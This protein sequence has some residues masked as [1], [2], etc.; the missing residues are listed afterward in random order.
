MGDTQIFHYVNFLIGKGMSP[1]RQIFDMNMPG[2]YLSD[3]IGTAIFGSSDIGWRLYDYTL[4]A[5]LTAAFIFIAIE[6]DWLAGLYAGV[7][8]ALIHGSEGPWQTAQRDQVMTVLVILGYAFA[9]TG[10]RR[11]RTLFFFFSAISFSLAATIK[12]TA[13]LAA[14]LLIVLALQHLKYQRLSVWPYVRAITIGTFLIL[15]GTLVFLE[16]RGSVYFF[17]SNNFAFT[18]FYSLMARP[19]FLYLLRHCAPRWLMVLLMLATLLLFRNRSWRNWEIQAVL[20]GVLFGLVSY[21]VQ[22]KGFPYHRYPFIAFALLW[23]GLEF[24]I[25]L[26][27]RGFNRWLAVMG[28]LVGSLLIGPFYLSQ[29]KNAEQSNALPIAL[30]RDLERFPTSQLWGNVQCLDAVDGCYSALYRLKIKQSTGLMGDQLIF[31]HQ[32]NSAII[33]FRE[34]FLRG[35]ELAPPT[36]FVETNFVYG[37]PPSFRKIEAWPQFDKFLR[38]NYTVVSE[39]TFPTSP[40]DSEAPG[41]RIYFRAY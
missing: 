9:F 10:I 40:G 36:V 29:V 38:Q 22:A 18:K 13:T 31:S 17:F 27:A 35:L 23:V 3:F 20:S 33:E 2:S 8:F 41:Y 26:Q 5:I 21:F 32:P 39:R 28:L 15:L 24:V 4:L 34:Q 12:P 14:F 7:L 16:W 37:E 1:Y 19:S 6:Y 30:V 11:R 25:A